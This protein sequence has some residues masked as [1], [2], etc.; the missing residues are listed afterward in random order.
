VSLNDKE[1][2][3]IITR[4]RGMG[5]FKSTH[6]YSDKESSELVME[7]REAFKEANLALDAYRVK[8]I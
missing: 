7:L 2:N 8:E 4:F 6:T 1:Y 3:V 5:D